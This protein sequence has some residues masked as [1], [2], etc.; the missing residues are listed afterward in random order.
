MTNDRVVLLD[1][2]G[3]PCG[4]AQRELV[5]GPATPLHLAFSCYVVRDDGAMLVT[6]RALAKRSWPGVWTNAFC[7]HPRPGERMRTAIRRHART[8]LGITV[9]GVELVLPDFRYRATDSSGTV[10]N[11]VCPVYVARTDDVPRPD[12]GE[13]AELRWVDPEDLGRA[14]AAAPWAFSPWLVEQA[15]RLAHDDARAAS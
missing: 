8:E 4:S 5:H 3:L 1:A 9:R 14:L 15:G 13:V 11:E 12:A 2:R 10:E 6:R 7:G